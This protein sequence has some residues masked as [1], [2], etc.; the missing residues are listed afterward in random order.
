LR[1][2]KPGALPAAGV[3]ARK[4]VAIEMVAQYE[5]DLRRTALRY[6][7][8]E[9]DAD[10]AYQR[11]LEILLTKAPTDDLR[12]LIRWTQTVV[13]HE[14]LA[15][16][17]SRERML[18]SPSPSGGI[19][20]RDWV[21]LIPAVGGDPAERAERSEAIARSREALRAL[22]PQELRALTLLAEG[23]TYAEIGQMTGYSKTKINRCLAEGRERFRQM[24]A[25]GE[26]GS[27]CVA[28]RPLLSSVCDGEASQEDAT[29][30]REHLRACAGCRSTMRA[31]RAAP[32]AVAALA[33]TL[34]ASRSLLERA[35][36]LFA[37]LHSRLPGQGGAADS[38]MAQVAATG[39][40]RGTGMAALAKVLAICVGTAGGAAACVATGVAPAPI[41]FGADRAK[42]P[43]LERPAARIADSLTGESAGVTYEPAPPK[44]DPPSPEPP[45]EPKPSPAPAPSSSAGGVE[46][47]PEA[48][49]A[50]AT[51]PAE[52]GGSSSS[53]SGSAAGE[54]G[55]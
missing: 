18:G 16:R 22:K 50:V 43:T 7:L 10:D 35:H 55:P 47:T 19:P 34:P 41:D 23:Y 48:A 5:S 45:P 1:L 11:S 14:A 20:D 36:E 38:S 52:E 44:P 6:S 54:F 37:G 8:C 24:L 53:S 46:F 25:S 27:R 9:D 4:R 30:L 49:P 21:T 3:S 28:M 51:P 32:G 2:G 26:D 17:H 31:Y 42:P 15:V 39:G 29:T 40:T 33:P 12:E 13:K